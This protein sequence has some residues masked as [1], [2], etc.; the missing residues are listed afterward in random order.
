VKDVGLLPDVKVGGIVSGLAVGL[1]E[2]DL[3]REQQ[4]ETKSN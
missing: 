1:F 2:G 3:E 4:Y